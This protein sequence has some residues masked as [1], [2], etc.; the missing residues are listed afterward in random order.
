MH[1]HADGQGG[2]A[3]LEGTARAGDLQPLG[4]PARN[5]RNTHKSN[6]KVK[7]SK[8]SKT[9]EPEG[10]GKVANSAYENQTGEAQPLLNLTA[11]TLIG[12]LGCGGSGSRM[13]C[14]ATLD[15]WTRLHQPGNRGAAANAW[16]SIF[17]LEG[18]AG[19]N[20]EA[21]L[22]T[23]VAIS[24]RKTCDNNCTT[25]LQQLYNSVVELL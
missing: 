5:Q 22:T 4:S 15:S 24:A 9:N 17:G 1:P 16:K 19:L 8:P 23:L 10:N 6:S 18:F 21:G 3:D 7:G 25:T 12:R 11:L 2:S 13:R 20:F 14:D